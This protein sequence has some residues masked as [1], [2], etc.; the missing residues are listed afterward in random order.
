MP[1]PMKIAKAELHELDASFSQ[2]INPEK[3]VKVQFNPETL[4]VKFSNN[5][6]APGGGGDQNGTPSLQYVG[7][8]STSLSLQVWFDLTVPLAAGEQAV[9]DVRT[10]T[11]KMVYFMT[12][13]QKQLAQDTTGFIP[14]AV[15]FLWGS[16]QFDGMMTS[17][18]ESLEYFSHEGIP[19]RA[20]ITMSISQ[21]KIQ[22]VTFRATNVAGGVASVGTSALTLIKSGDTLQGIADTFGG[23][24]PTIAAANG[25]ENPRLPPVGKLIHSASS[26]FKKLF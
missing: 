9:S 5:I 10:Y 7:S 3:W 22:Q 13:T 18:D 24:W 16:F 20:S 12:P 8:G 21:Q 6:V 14:P 15:R 2:E 25:I 1:V 23:H 26:L 17:L 4:T 11:E 19:L